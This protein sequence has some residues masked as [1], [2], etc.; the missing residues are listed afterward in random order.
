M[1]PTKN[2]HIIAIGSGLA[3][4]MFLLA[5]LWCMGCSRADNWY[6]EPTHGGKWRSCMTHFDWDGSITG[7]SSPMSYDESLWWSET[8]G[9]KQVKP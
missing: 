1:K 6:V 2:S 7:C 9:G 4:V 8:S 3:V 5:V